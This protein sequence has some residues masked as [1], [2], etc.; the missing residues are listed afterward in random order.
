MVQNHYMT[1]R[2][3]ILVGGPNGAGKTTFSMKDIAL[4]G[5]VYLG[6]DA[7]AAEISPDNPAAAAIEAGRLF[8]ERFDQLIQTE[9]RLV[10][11][12]TL[13]GK[14][15]IRMI[16]RAKAAGLYVEIKFVFVD[17]ENTSLVRVSQRVRNGGHHVP[18][19]DVRRRFAR[20]IVNFW[21]QYR[22]LADEWLLIYNE[23]SGPLEVASGVGGEL[24]I[25]REELFLRFQQ[26]IK[27]APP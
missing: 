14:S 3:L 27:E 2:K 25:Y 23:R 20:S 16:S 10:I 17:S 21:T 15:L 13:S 4:H 26:I 6:A 12:S 8:L 11:E 19:D 18:D 9:Q 1:S 5:G 22:L 7:I 24:C